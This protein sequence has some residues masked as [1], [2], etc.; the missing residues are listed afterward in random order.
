[1][2]VNIKYDND[3]SRVL[4]NV[5]MPVTVLLITSDKLIV[6]NTFFTFFYSTWKIILMSLL[7]ITVES[8]RKLDVFI[9]NYFDKT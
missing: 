4:S 7:P 3:K 5:C 1:M 9:F 8:R 2:V 6:N